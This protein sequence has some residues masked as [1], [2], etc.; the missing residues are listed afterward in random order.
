MTSSSGRGTRGVDL[1]DRPAVERVALADLTTSLEFYVRD[2]LLHHGMDAEGLAVRASA[3]S[4]DHPEVRG[5]V[6]VVEIQLP[7]HLP[8]AG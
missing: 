6:V 1:L 4:S 8:H 5:E 7:T 3:R 2:Y